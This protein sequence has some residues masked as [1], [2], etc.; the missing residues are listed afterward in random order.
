[1]EGADVAGAAQAEGAAG[2]PDAGGG[3]GGVPGG[4]PDR[5]VVPRLPLKAR[6][7]LWLRRVRFKLAWRLVKGMD[8]MVVSKAAIEAASL[9][10]AKMPGWVDD[11]LVGQHRKAAMVTARI[12]H[13]QEFFL[14]ACEIGDPSLQAQ[15]L[16]DLY[17]RVRQATMSRRQRER[18]GYEQALRNLP[19]RPPEERNKRRFRPAPTG[20]TAALPAAPGKPVTASVPISAAVARHSYPEHP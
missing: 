4:R 14:L 7:N 3:E 11:L 10:F 13:V 8:G 6:V 20:K 12:E 15:Q 18:M 5:A 19:V 2:A 9:E 17:M 16:A 1:M